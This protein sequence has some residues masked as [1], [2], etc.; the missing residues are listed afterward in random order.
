[1]VGALS[2]AE[3]FYFAE[4]T[5]RPGFDPYLTI[6]NPQLANVQ[7]KMTFMRG[8]GT[9][10]E[11][12]SEVPAHSR[13]TVFVPNILGRGND[14]AHDF[15]CKVESTGGQGIVVERPMYFDY[16]G[17]WTGGSDVVGFSP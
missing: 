2:P 15:S 3:A 5:C 9:T 16:N 6:L 12:L 17:V 14:A 1:M 11:Q 4:G 8:D 7:V 13:F 10:A